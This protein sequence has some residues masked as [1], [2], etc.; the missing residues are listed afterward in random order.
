MLGP[1]VARAAPP[2]ARPATTVAPR[3][4]AIGAPRPATTVAPP[5]APPVAPQPAPAVAPPVAQ[6][7]PEAAVVLADRRLVYRG[8]INDLWIDF[9]KSRTAPTKHDL[10]DA[11]RAVLDGKAVSEPVTK[12]VG[13]YIHD[14]K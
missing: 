2:I 6:V 13:C 3:P 10:A 4:A 8:R 9:G 7:T 1:P 11:L 5:V 12:S 14:L